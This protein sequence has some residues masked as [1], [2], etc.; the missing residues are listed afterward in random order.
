MKIPMNRMIKEFKRQT[1]VPKGMPRR[2]A[3]VD[4]AAKNQGF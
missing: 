4:K 2:R 3:K 1:G